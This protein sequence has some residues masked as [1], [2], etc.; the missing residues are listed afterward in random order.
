[1]PHDEPLADVSAACDAAFYLYM[2]EAADF[3]G[4]RSSPRLA[5]LVVPSGSEL[6]VWLSA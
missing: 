6:G 5:G 1:M 3:A 4:G 2:R